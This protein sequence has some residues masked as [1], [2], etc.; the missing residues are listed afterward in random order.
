MSATSTIS[1]PKTGNALVPDTSP[2]LCCVI[3]I[4]RDATGLPTG[5]RVFPS[6]A[7]DSHIFYPPTGRAPSPS[8]PQELAWVVNHLLPGEKLRIEAKSSPAQPALFA[9]QVFE[10][11]HPQQYVSTGPVAS[12]FRNGSGYAWSYNVT[13][14]GGAVTVPTLD[15][16]I[17]VTEEP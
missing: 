3:S 13:L 7:N 15:P 11:A 5:L 10:I 9:S 1:Q 17:I 4:G 6:R 14:L 8:R 16:T 2:A 12:G